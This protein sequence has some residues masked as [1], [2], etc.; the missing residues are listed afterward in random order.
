[1]FLEDRIST[2]EINFRFFA[3]LVAALLGANPLE[4]SPILIFKNNLSLGVCFKILKGFG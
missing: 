3:S 2:R 1:M 4:R